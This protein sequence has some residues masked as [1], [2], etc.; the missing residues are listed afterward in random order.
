LDIGG[1]HG[2]QFVLL[3]HT[4]KPQRGYNPFVQARVKTSDT[5]V[6]A[7]K[8][9][10]GCSWEEHCGSVGAG[11]GDEKAESCKVVRP[12]CTPLVIHPIRRMYVVVVR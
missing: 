8:P 6:E 12:L 11:V 2:Q 1:Q 7:V 4:Y 10:P 5:S 3:R 9:D